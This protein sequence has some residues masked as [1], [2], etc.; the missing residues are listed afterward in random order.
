MFHLRGRKKKKKLSTAKEKNE[1][2]K[3]ITNYSVYFLP[4]HL[5]VFHDV[6]F[7]GVGIHG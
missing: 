6:F 1:E 4:F 2:K 7:A 5:D 3:I